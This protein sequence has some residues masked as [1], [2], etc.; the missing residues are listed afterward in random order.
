MKYIHSLYKFNSIE[1]VHFITYLSE[2]MYILSHTL[3]NHN[4]FDKKIH[5]DLILCKKGQA[6]PVLFQLGHL[7]TVVTR[8]VQ[9]KANQ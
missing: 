1:H 7:Y 9:G 5:M 4:D 3:V 6:F 8:L 2:S